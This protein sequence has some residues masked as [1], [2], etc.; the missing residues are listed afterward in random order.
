MENTILIEVRD[1]VIQRIVSNDETT[2]V[3]ILD[4]D[5]LESLEGKARNE[6]ENPTYYQCDGILLPSQIKEEYIKQCTQ[7]AEREEESFLD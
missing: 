2:K 7:I 3:L 1:G 4:H 5:N 6:A